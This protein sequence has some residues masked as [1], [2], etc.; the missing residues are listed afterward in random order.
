MSSRTDAAQGPGDGPGR[1]TVPDRTPG[2][3]VVPGLGHVKALDGFRGLAIIGVL[4]LHFGLVSCGWVGVQIFFVLSG[5]LI[6]SIL[7][8]DRHLTFGAYLKRFYWRRSLRIFPL[9]FGYLA[10]ITA[11]FVVA[12]VPAPFERYW[13]YLYSYTFNYVALR[14]GYNPGIFFG[15][16]WSLSIEE[17]FYLLWPA[18]VYLLPR[19]AFQ[20]VILALVTLGPAIRAVTA[21]ILSGAIDTPNYLGRNIYGLTFC[22]LDAFAVGA[23]VAV[24]KEKLAKQEGRNFLICSLIVLAYGQVSA[25]M[26]TGSPAFDTSLGY[27]LPMFGGGRHI[28]GYTLLNGWAASLLLL[29]SRPNAISAFLSRPALVYIGK[30]SYGIYLFHPSIQK[31]A[32]TMVGYRYGLERLAVSIFC[33]GAVVAVSSLSYRW[34]ESPFLR[35]KAKR[36]VAPEA[37]D[38]TPRAD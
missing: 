17:Q 8:A 26:A 33:F 16:L 12:G 7:L 29:A 15:H 23:A 3:G 35:L 13:P 10:V 22:Q 27:G 11:A 4:L 6:T 1:G 34:Y 32:I 28:W 38:R 37:I 20:W 21:T 5:F 9:Y 14:P 36:F 30:I 24:F 25:M 31:L 19:R 2:P 18:I